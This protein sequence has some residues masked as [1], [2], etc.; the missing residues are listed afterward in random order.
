MTAPRLATTGTPQLTSM[1]LA[2]AMIATLK[3]CGVRFLFG[4]P[5]GGSSLDLI[6]AA[7]KAGMRFILC[8]GETAATLA[9]AAAAELTG[10]PGIVLT[11][12]GPGAASAANGVAYAHLE[13]APLLL[14]CDSRDVG[15]NLPPHQ[16]FDLQALYR[17]ITKACVR[18]S[19]ESG[20]D[21][22]PLSWR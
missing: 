3:S 6:A 18:I 14:I 2:E 9:A 4:V 11:A 7:D 22:L 19:P 12:I 1:T 8:R 15:G 21:S 16:V 20:A 17:P 10:A 13:R 5:G